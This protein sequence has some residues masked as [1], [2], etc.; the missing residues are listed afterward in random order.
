M[1]RTIVA[2]VC[3]MVFVGF[4]GARA[5]TVLVQPFGLENDEVPV[6]CEVEEIISAELSKVGCD[7]VKSSPYVMP[8][9]IVTGS[10]WV[11]DGNTYASVN[12][13]DT[14]NNQLIASRNLFLPKDDDQCTEIARA[15]A[16]EISDP[17]FYA[18][19]QNFLD[20]DSGME[21]VYVPGGRFR[22]GQGEKATGWA[23]VGSFFMARYEV[24]QEQWVKV[25]GLN[26]SVF[27]GE[28][29]PVENISWYDANEYVRRLSEKTDRRYR[30]PTEAE[31]EYAARTRG[32]NF[33]WAGT[34]ADDKL[35]HFAWTKENSG[36]AT[37]QVGLRRA[38]GLGIY[39]MSGNVWEWTS[40]R[41]F[42][43]GASNSMGDTT[44]RKVIRGGSYMMDAG[45]S[46]TSAREAST[47]E[48][49]FQDNGMRLVL[50]LSPV[51]PDKSKTVAATA[52][53]EPNRP[54]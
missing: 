21:F 23:T 38:N 18:R 25:M 32:R 48:S 5:E 47:A 50:E 54:Q 2:V 34:S 26:P 8:D 28:K 14:V 7:L 12:V 45:Y 36:L 29:N 40:D 42:E 51:K 17:P 37:H 52:S 27:V 3:L 15:V 9:I 11:S 20:V 1:K 46:R 33:L 19:K 6:P 24:T 49:R 41:Y 13:A 16:A 35:L 4:I 22:M 10:L 53:P 31:W 30:L 44:E 39:D 43:D